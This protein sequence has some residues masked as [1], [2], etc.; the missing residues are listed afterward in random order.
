MNKNDIRPHEILKV[1]V[2]GD[3]G[4]EEELWAKVV[5][6]DPNKIY[7]T[8]LSHTSNIYKGACV[9]SFDTRVSPV[10]IESIS[11]HH[12]GVIDLAQIDI[13]Q[14]GSNMF[15][16]DNEVDESD[17][18]SSIDE[19]S[20]EEEEEDTSG[21]FIDDSGG[22]GELPADAQE[23]DTAWDAWRPTTRG[24]RH[25]KETVEHIEQIAKTELDNEKFVSEN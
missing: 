7:V 20:E 24:G 12:T 6:N 16:F 19:M 15:V 14:I 22:V 25:F 21:S 4:I 2:E 23:I 5:A 18:D 11:E 1:L 17:S 8:Y 10:D 13:S 9:Y 3:D